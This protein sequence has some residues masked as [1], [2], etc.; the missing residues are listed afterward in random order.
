MLGRSL[1][2][3]IAARARATQPVEFD[4]C[5]DPAIL[6]RLR[7]GQGCVRVTFQGLLGDLGWYAPT[8]LPAVRRRQPRAPASPPSDVPV[9]AR[10]PPPARPSAW[11]AAR[12]VGDGRFCQGA[13][14]GLDHRDLLPPFFPVGRYEDGVF[15]TTLRALDDAALFGHVPSALVHEPAT[16]RALGLAATSGAP[17]AWSASASSSCSA[18]ARLAS[19]A[20]FP[21][22]RRPPARRSAA[23]RPPNS[24]PSSPLRLWRQKALYITHLERLLADHGARAERL[25]R[26]RPAPPRRHRRAR[27]AP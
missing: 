13:I 20:D 12:T 22:P 7:A 6:R 10:S 3:L 26:R 23:S 16:E 4:D 19:Q 2:A 18:S 21:R 8:W 9:T 15:R 17:A 11:S 24:A 5:L 25:G 27:R 14:L 1:P